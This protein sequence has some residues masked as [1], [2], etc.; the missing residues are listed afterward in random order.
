MKIDPDFMPL[1]VFEE[2]AAEYDQ[3]F[4]DHR[5]VY[6]DELKRISEAI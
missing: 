5:D 2:Y 6:L 1:T 4:F 3:W